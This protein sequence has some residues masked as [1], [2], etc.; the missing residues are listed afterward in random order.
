MRQKDLT[1]EFIYN[2]YS[3]LA[4]A[5]TSTLTRLQG[6]RDT[7]VLLAAAMTCRAAEE[8]HVCVDLSR[9]ADEPI[10]ADSDRENQPRCPPLD[11]W[12]AC[13]EASPLVGAPGQWRPLILDRGH[14]LY[15]QRYHR[16]EQLIA[17][18]LHAARA[19][20]PDLPTDLSLW[21]RKLQRYFP[22]AKPGQ[23]DDQM[24]AAAVALLQRL[25]VISGAPGT[26][27][28]TT[29]A[30]IIALLLDIHVQQPLRFALCAPTGKAAARLSEAL[31]AAAAALPASTQ[32]SGRFPTEAATIHRLLGYRRNRFVFN[33]DNPLP[34]DVVVVDEASMIDISLMAR[35]L[36]AVPTEA[37]LIILGDHNQLSSVEAG[38]VMGDICQRAGSKGRSAAIDSVY[39]RLGI[40]GAA[41]GEAAPDQ[42]EPLDN[43]VIVLTRNYRFSA[44]TGIGALIRAVNAG[45]SDAVRQRLQND[46]IAVEWKPA[47]LTAPVRQQLRNVFREGYGPVFTARSP[48]GALAALEHFTI[49]SALTG[50]PWGTERLNRWIESLGRKAGWIETRDSWYP[51]RPVM[52]R[53][54]D[55]RTGLF[56]GDV[57]VVWPE[58]LQGQRQ[59]RIWF[60]TAAGPL[61]A[62]S[63]SQL[64]EH[65]TAFA[66]TVHKS[67]GSE[68]RRVVLILPEQ[69][70][71]ILTREWVYTGLSRAR[72][73]IVLVADAN[74]LALAIG[75]R[76][77]RVSG[78]RAALDDQARDGAAI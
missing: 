78:L 7:A 25:C 26:G 45:Q 12:L 64:P 60:R 75:R 2:N 59:V 9:M 63:P 54:N 22:D 28:T 65:Q 37:R 72:E 66:L 53:R 4:A 48:E 5:L 41:S 70:N 57:G 21:A 62:F 6:G 10:G 34:A 30:R 73:K 39:R 76:I 8:G 31:R 17:N 56:N 47:P 29:A 11:K 13:L 27:K 14:F 38:A 20:P 16:D 77:E 74:V 33:A 35:L 23:N 55:Y 36:E 32:D 44:R 61:K 67:Q 49:L 68:Y 18:Y 71:P 46:D 52:I 50:G 1:I 43:H 19:T 15:L 3:G 42:A 51:G 58:R 40:G 69:D 24:A